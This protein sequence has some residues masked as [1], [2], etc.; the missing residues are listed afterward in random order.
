MKAK[1]LLRRLIR[2]AADTPHPAEQYYSP[3]LSPAEERALL[4]RNYLLLMAGQAALGLIGP[5]ILGIAVEPRLDE[6]VFHVAASSD[7]DALHEDLQDIADD[8][9]GL[10][11]GGPEQL[12]R[13]S[14]Q[15]HIGPADTSWPGRPHALLYLAKP[16]TEPP[17]HKS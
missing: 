17:I 9:D 7:S 1:N 14:V 5:D 10:L 13:I 3:D 12:T 15:I 8:L 4:R 6:V 16:E 2:W 11:A